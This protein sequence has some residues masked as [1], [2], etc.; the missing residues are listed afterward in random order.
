MKKSTLLLL[1]S[2]FLSISS[3]GTSDKDS[4]LAII[5][6]KR[7]DTTALKA[8]SR[9]SD[10]LYNEQQFKESITYAEIGQQ[11]GEQL[12]TTVSGKEERINIIKRLSQLYTNGAISHT[13][14]GNMT[15]AIASEKR[16]LELSL[17]IDDPQAAAVSHQNIG[18]MHAEQRNY[19]EGIK[20]LLQALRISEK[21]K[22]EYGI[23]VAYLSI[24]NLYCYDDNPTLALQH[25]NAALKIAVKLKDQNAI[26][27]IYSG[28]GAAYSDQ[29]KHDEGIDYIKKALNI[30]TQLDDKSQ[31]ATMYNQLSTIYSEINREDEALKNQLLSLEINKELENIDGMASDYINMGSSYFFLK[32]YKAAREHLNQGLSL[33]RDLGNKEWLMN[34]Y[35]NLSMLDSAENKHAQALSNYKNYI[36]YRDSITNE[37]NIKALVQAQLTYDFDKKQIAQKAEQDKKDLET[38]KKEDQQAVIRNSLI[39]GFIL[40]LCLA[41][42]I[43]KGY[44]SKQKANV[45][46]LKQKNEVEQKNE[47]IKYQKEI[48]EEKQKEILDSI[49]Y[50][51]RIQGS[52]LASKTLLAENLHEHFILFEPKDIVS[53]DFYWASKL[54]NGR[55]AFVT[56]DSTG[57]GVPG[58]IMSMLNISCLNEAV[59]GQK[60]NS[61]KEI[62]NYTRS[63]I[64][65]HLSNDGSEEGGKDGMDCSLISLDITGRRMTIACA[66]NPVWIVRDNNLIEF[67]P[68]K[69]P[70]GRHDRENTSFTEQEVELKTNDMIYTLT[71]GM[72]DQ[73]GGEK[74]KK[75]MYKKLKEL[76]VQSAKLE[77]KQQKANILETLK[78][79]KGSLDQVDDILICGIR[80]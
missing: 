78:N 24:G 27:A 4:L 51:Q 34:A 52:L 74:G 70:V 41:A 16:S 35:S 53:G 76:L 62:L 55:F 30:F 64:I 5:N 71:D 20:N 22:D 44:R 66:N 21:L 73:F 12:L 47:I 42:A 39:V 7:S 61:P 45:E 3:F 8:Y 50:A 26:A 1:L 69:M 59:Q 33:A 37:D 46:I 15:A 25:L 60:L 13:S 43:Y 56:A 80:V 67:Y 23:M 40:L 77:P 10:V 32:N 48:V 2:L 68:D 18:I 65:S 14:I 72:A 49:N 11:L 28:L 63:R 9:L 75:F 79:W 57:H 58:A 17:M 54:Q 29:G 36:L 38:L 6:Q 31:I 19:V